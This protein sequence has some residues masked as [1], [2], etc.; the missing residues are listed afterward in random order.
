MD[1]TVL[2]QG[3]AYDP[4]FIER[5]YNYYTGKG[6]KVHVHTWYDDKLK[7][8]SVPYTY[9][10]LEKHDENI[11]MEHP[12]HGLKPSSLYYHIK[13]VTEGLENINS[14]YV[15]KIRTDEFFSDL[16]PLI[17]EL[18]TSPKRIVT[19]NIFL[20][21]QKSHPFN[22]SDHLIASEYT[23]MYHAFSMLL[24]FFKSYLFLTQKNTLFDKISS[25]AMFGK[26]YTGA[27]ILLTKAF[28]YSLGYTNIKIKDMYDNFTIIPVSTLGEYV[29]TANY[30]NKR[31]DSKINPF[32][33]QDLNYTVNRICEI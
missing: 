3:P 1:I 28:L 9:S 19:A 27:Q 23:S 24:G 32:P 10:N 15:I 14:N 21:S 18:K 11:L 6:Y 30:Q 20:R 17:D 7:E 29:I 2:I 13:N 4:T 8:L 22:I 16:T 26:Y 5:N 33:E 31:F 12:T 25:D